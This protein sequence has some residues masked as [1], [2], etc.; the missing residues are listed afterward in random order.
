MPCRWASP[1]KV[2]DM[3]TLVK[4]HLSREYEDIYEYEYEYEYE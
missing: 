2:N 1:K 4:I 3:L